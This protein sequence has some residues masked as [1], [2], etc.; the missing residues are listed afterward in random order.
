MD[1]HMRSQRHHPLDVQKG[2]LAGQCR[3]GRLLRQAEEAFHYRDWRGV[4]MGEFMAMLDSY[5]RFYN[6]ERP[7]ESLGWMSPCQYRRS[8]GLVA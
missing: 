4:N 6:E 8:L 2:V 5:L 1:R 3:N 7:K